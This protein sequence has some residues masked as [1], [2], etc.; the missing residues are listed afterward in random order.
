VIAVDA[1]LADSVSAADG[2]LHAQGAGWNR[3]YAAAIPTVHG[4]IGLGLILRI[5]AA[6][7]ADPHALEVRLQGPDGA[8]VRL[9]QATEDPASAFDRI[10]GNLRLDPPPPGSP[11]QEEEVF[12]VALNFDG[13]PLERAGTYRFVVAIDGADVREI[14][15]GV[16][17][18]A[19][20][21]TS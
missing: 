16:A 6:S 11:V 19:S 12:P 4:R 2:K 15:F 7:A 10:Q 18:A 21:T 17:Q 8:P 5:P 9:G 3:I 14:A 1:F 13:L 20:N